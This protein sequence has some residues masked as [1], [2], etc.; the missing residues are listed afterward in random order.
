MQG[1]AAAIVVPGGSYT[2]TGENFPTG[3]GTVGVTEGVS[4]NVL[5]LT[6]TNTVTPDGP[7]AA[8]IDFSFVN[9][10]PGSPLAFN[11]ASFWRIDINDVP[12]AAPA[13]FDNFFLYFTVDGTA[14]NPIS[15]FG[16]IDYQGNSN[17]INPALGPVYF[18]TPF[19]PG[20]A[21]T[22]LDLFISANPYSFIGT[23]GNDP[24]LVNDFHIAAH[25]T[26]ETPVSV[27]EPATLTLLGAALL[28]FGAAMRRRRF[29]T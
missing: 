19:T 16:G 26:L 18:G 2:V 24:A 1:A 11:T 17:P 21:I 25:L 12:L 14:V 28:G 4:N 5:G 3:T 29:S 15:D 20:P 23:G 10:T 7:N 22:D 8:W 27:P 13:L 6:L 9:P